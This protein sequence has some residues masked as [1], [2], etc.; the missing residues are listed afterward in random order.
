MIRL[1]S[2]YLEALKL[3]QNVSDVAAADDSAAANGE[4]GITHL[5]I[6]LLLESEKQ[7]ALPFIEAA[8]VPT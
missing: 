4:L 6:A 2:Q 5:D 7:Y 3:V 8:P 1:V